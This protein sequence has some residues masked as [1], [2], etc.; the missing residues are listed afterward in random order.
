MLFL[1]KRR[2]TYPVTVV[3]DIKIFILEVNYG[4]E[5]VDDEIK[6]E[7]YRFKRKGINKV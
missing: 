3:D 2:Y 1:L 7:N 6:R 4:D 5:V